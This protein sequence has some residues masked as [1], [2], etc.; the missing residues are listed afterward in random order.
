VA[1]TIEAELQTY[2]GE[3]ICRLPQAF[4]YTTDRECLA[5][6]LMADALRWHAKADIGLVVPGPV[7]NK[8][9]PSG[10]LTRERLWSI[11]HSPGN[12][13]Q[14]KLPGSQLETLIQRGQD[15][16]L[17][18]DRHPALRGQERGLMH[19]SG[20]EII[21][22]V[23]YIQNNP[24]QPNRIYHVAASDFEFEPV[25]GY[26]LEDWGVDPSYDMS[27]V[28]RDVLLDY[29]SGTPDLA[30]RLGRLR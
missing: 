22:G 13:G 24:L 23:V 1:K 14:V 27:A 25:W 19:L 4:D 26:T 17:A 2:L 7:F 6:N 9:L 29:L 21:D 11:C 15:Q 12:P 5:G 18:A 10:D 16:D 20:A 28:M 3:V 8:D 30:I